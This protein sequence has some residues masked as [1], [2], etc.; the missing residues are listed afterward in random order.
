M[1]ANSRTKMHYPL[2]CG[3]GS[4]LALRWVG[5][6]SPSHPSRGL[7]LVAQL[8][9]GPVGRRKPEGHFIII[10]SDGH[11]SAFRTFGLTCFR[12]ISRSTH[13]AYES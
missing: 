4:C 7:Y 9:A 5:Q 13:F 10:N 3:G 8:N 11:L 2:G 6:V 1:L 12:R